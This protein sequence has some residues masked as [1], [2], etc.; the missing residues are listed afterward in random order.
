[1]YRYGPVVTNSLVGDIL[2]FMEENIFFF[3]KNSCIMLLTFT[4][5][6]PF[7]SSRNK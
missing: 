5:T 3:G 7:W 1:M 6:L 4:S 2:G